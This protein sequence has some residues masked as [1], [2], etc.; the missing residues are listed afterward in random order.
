MAFSYY[1]AANMPFTQ[2]QR[3]E[4]L[5]MPSTLERLL[6]LRKKVLELVEERQTQYMGC[7]HCGMPL[8][9]VRDVFS[10]DGA[11]GATSNYVN[12]YGYI[13]QVTTLRTVM[14]PTCL[15]FEGRP[16]TDNR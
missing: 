14:D 16:S 7:T 11:E 8:G 13:H 15:H 3:L 10:F 6:A 2:N 12:D 4:F 1:L 5:R 9:L